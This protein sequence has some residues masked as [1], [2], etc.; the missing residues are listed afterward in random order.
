MNAT[1]FYSAQI[2][3]FSS[4]KRMPHY[5][6]GQGVFVRASRPG[7]W[8]QTRLTQY[9]I[10]NRDNIVTPRLSI[11]R[12]WADSTLTHAIARDWNVPRDSSG[13]FPTIG[14]EITVTTDQR[15]EL[16]F[17][18]P[19]IIDSIESGRISGFESLFPFECIVGTDTNL[20]NNAP[21]L[22]AEESRRKV[23]KRGR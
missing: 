3:L 19:R 2:Q 21:E 20:W 15:G 22:Y 4:Q 1:D 14:L 10:S 5:V 16:I 6:R 23:V 8:H 9:P 7:R 11:D 13:L 12:N 18:V 17:C